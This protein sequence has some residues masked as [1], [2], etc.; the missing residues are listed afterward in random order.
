MA[1]SL[2]PGERSG[3]CTNCCVRYVW[4]GAPR[5]TVAVCPRCYSLLERTSYLLAWPSIYNEHP[6][7]GSTPCKTAPGNT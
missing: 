4:K 3:K 7:E 6:D 1:R 2:Q 5:V